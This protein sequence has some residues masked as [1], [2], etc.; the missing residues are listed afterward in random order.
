MQFPLSIGMLLARYS[1]VSISIPSSISVPA[2]LFT[3]FVIQ[4][5]VANSL[6]TLL[7]SFIVILYFR[8]GLEIPLCHTEWQIPV[9]IHTNSTDTLGDTY[10]APLQSPSYVATF[11][12]HKALL[13]CQWVAW[14]HGHR[15]IYLTCRKRYNKLDTIICYVHSLGLVHH[16]ILL[17]MWSRYQMTSHVHG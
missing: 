2:S 14:S 3:N 17:M 8:V 5:P 16:I 1:I 4:D 15:N 11:G 6:V 7:A 9:L 12:T 10:R 13:Q